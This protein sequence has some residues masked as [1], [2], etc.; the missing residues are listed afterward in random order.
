MLERAAAKKWGIDAKLCK[1]SLHQVKGGKDQIA[2][3][4]DLAADAAKLSVPKA[5][6]LSFKKKSER[7]YVGK[8]DIKSFDSRA[9]VTG[10]ANFGADVQLD[11]LVHAVVVRPRSLNG[12]IK[13]IDEKRALATPGVKKIL[14]LPKWKGAGPAFQPLGGVAIIAEK[15]FCRHARCSQLAPQRGLLQG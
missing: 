3:F 7:R 12:T 8:E 9:L 14:R 4:G 13:S 2:S 10:K 15:H 11:G 5:S 6:E 1:A